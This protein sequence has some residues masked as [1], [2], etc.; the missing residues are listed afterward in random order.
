MKPLKVPIC[1]SLDNEVLAKIRI[2]AKADSRSVA[3]YINNVLRQH[4]NRQKEI[5]GRRACGVLFL[6]PAGGVGFV[7]LR[8]TS[9][10]VRRASVFAFG[11][12]LGA[13]GLCLPSR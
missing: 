12:N 9:P 10:Q 4:L 11:E 13:G 6:P 1:I 5:C 7:P 8:G 2:L 3:Q